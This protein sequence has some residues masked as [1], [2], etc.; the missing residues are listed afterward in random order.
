PYAANLPVIFAG[1]ASAGSGGG[2]D[3][4]T[5]P[6]SFGQLP[7]ASMDPQLLSPTL[8]VPKEPPKLAV[9]PTIVAPDVAVTPTGQIGDP[10]SPI[11]GLLSAGRGK[12]GIGDGCCGGVGDYG[13]NSYGPYGPGP[14]IGGHAGTPPRLIYQTEPD[15]SD[16]ARKSHTQGIVTLLL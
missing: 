13:G 6:A 14:G 4:S 10:S 2:G 16:E 3:R 1:G 8:L 5:M 15:F 9:E 7:R 12:D 11:S